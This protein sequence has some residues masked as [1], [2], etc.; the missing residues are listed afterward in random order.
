MPSQGKATEWWK[1]CDV[2]PFTR[3]HI[4]GCI[5]QSSQRDYLRQYAC[6]T[7]DDSSLSVS[8]HDCSAIPLLRNLTV[9]FVGDSLM[10]ELHT[11]ANCLLP[12]G[13]V[14]FALNLVP[15]HE[16]LARQLRLVLST[17]DVVLFNFGLWYNFEP[18]AVVSEGV[19]ESLTP[20]LVETCL[21]RG[22]GDGGALGK[23]C[24]TNACML[25]PSGNLENVAYAFRRRLCER[26]MGSDAYASD[27]MR[28][29]S[30]L[31]AVA[32]EQR[33]RARRLIWRDNTPQHYATP[34]GYFPTFRNASWPSAGSCMPIKGHHFPLANE[35]NRL[36]ERFLAPLLSAP[37][38]A[39]ARLE[40]M[41]TWQHDVAHHAEHPRGK[42]DE[43][44][45]VAPTMRATTQRV[46]NFSSYLVSDCSHF[47]LHSAVS[48][49]WM[50]TLLLT[51]LFPRLEP[52]TL[53][54]T[55]ERDSS[56]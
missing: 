11:L 4:F 43:L 8:A 12:F 9:A 42:R 22:L 23:A 19:D 20:Q 14:A 51:V 38:N 24:S 48:R 3:R 41:S 1:S 2:L 30:T 25:D 53:A 16:P 13:T 46:G 5:N 17:A 31:S 55:T 32:A 56:T 50:E 54:S 29:A 39:P 47:C 45:E 26:A 37:P 15:H 34:S 10:G 33:W 27:L 6:S 52:G 28:F 36:A 49:N 7:C 21:A 40:R 18:P 35:R 44:E